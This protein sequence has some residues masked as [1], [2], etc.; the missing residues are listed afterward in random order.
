MKDQ[1]DQMRQSLPALS[2]DLIPWI[3]VGGILAGILIVT[4]LLR[5][6][7]R[8]VAG[9]YPPWTQALHALI[10]AQ[11]V[12]LIVMHLYELA[13]GVI[14]DN[15]RNFQGIA[16]AYCTGVLSQIVTYSLVLRE[17]GR[18]SITMIQA[19]ALCVPQ[20]ALLVCFVSAGL[21]SEPRPPAVSGMEKTVEDAKNRLPS[22]SPVPAAPSGAAVVDAQREAL[23][24]HPALGVAGSRMNSAFLERYH[25][26][27]KERPDYFGD[28]TWPIRLADETASELRER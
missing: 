12:S 4:S 25:R 3:V 14:S 1:T 20:M 23:R 5:L 6:A 9:F 16:G 2:D 10:G 17:E 24:R 18:N 11:I 27:Q 28:V 15:N 21:G 7:T 8:L 19:T 26:Y 22:A 13:L